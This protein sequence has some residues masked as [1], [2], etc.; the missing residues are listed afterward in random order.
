MIKKFRLIPL[1]IILMSM[2]LGIKI[3]DF[4]FGIERSFAQSN[5]PETATDP[6][7]KKDGVTDADNNAVREP[8]PQQLSSIPTRKEIEYLQKLAERRQ[9]LDRRADELDDR[10]KLLKAVELRIVERTES[11]KQIEETI[12]G[13]LNK[14]DER[15]QAQ[16]QSLVKIY[17]AMKPKQA[18]LIFNSLD[19]DVLISIVERMKESK[20]GAILAK[21]NLNKAKKLTMDLATRKKLPEIEG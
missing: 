7:E 6:A 19:D 8:A 15:E 12:E 21:M 13:L 17:S 4:S 10:E 3:V 9:E 1:A 18:A 20:M 2:V 11:L 5:S 14:H 16:L